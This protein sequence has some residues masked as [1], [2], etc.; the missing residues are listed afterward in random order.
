MIAR[1]NLWNAQSI[2]VEMQ[3]YSLINL[4][5]HQPR[6]E[7]QVDLHGNTELQ[8]DKFV[9]IYRMALSNGPNRSSSRF[10]TIFTLPLPLTFK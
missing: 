4:S 8:P 7:L 2:Y 1:I 10:L 6:L 3:N 5:N 9:K